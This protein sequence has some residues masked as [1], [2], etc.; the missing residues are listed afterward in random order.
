MLQ[1]ACLT[2]INKNENYELFIR[3]CEKLNE[4][5]GEFINKILR[6]HE[7]DERS[8]LEEI[9]SL[10]ESGKISVANEIKLNKFKYIIPN[11]E[12]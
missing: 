2:Q 12:Q 8:I 9:K 3:K 6:N 10:K 5:L 11:P 7:C 4:R 1:L